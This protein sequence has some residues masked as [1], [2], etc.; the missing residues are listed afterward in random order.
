V[1][2]GKILRVII[3]HY[4]TW[5]IH[6][7]YGR[8]PNIIL[9]HPHTL[10]Q[11]RKTTDTIIIVKT[12]ITDNLYCTI[13]MMSMINPK[14]NFPASAKHETSRHSCSLLEKMKSPKY[15]NLS[16]EMKPNVPDSVVKQIAENHMRVNHGKLMKNSLGPLAARP[17]GGPL[18]SM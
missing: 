12:A 9:Y 3:G 16:N 8:A 13:M 18:G 7:A 6:P 15:A 17:P 2:K 11:H 5:A 10:H 14:F 1:K 4:A